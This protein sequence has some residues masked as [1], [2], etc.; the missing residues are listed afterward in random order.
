MNKTNQDIQFV[1]H[2][3]E[4]FED[5]IDILFRELEL[6]TRWQRPSILLAIYSSEYVCTDAKTALKNRLVDML[7]FVQHI[8]VGND[9]N[10]DIPLF[11]SEIA[12]LDKGVFFIEGLRWGGGREGTRAYR[13]LNIGRE[14]FIDQRIRVIF[15]LTE[16]EA[17]D[18]ARY[19]PDF[20]SYRH[21]VV[22]FIDPPSSEQISARALES[23]WQG[24][25][26]YADTLED[27]DAGIA[28]REAMLRDLPEGDE[29]TANRANLLF[30]LGI[31]N[32]RR[33]DF[34][35]AA[36][37]IHITLEIAGKIQDKWFEA[38]CYNAVALVKTALGR[39]DEAVESLKQ[40]S[41]LAPG[42]TFH[43]NNLGNLYCQ[44]DRQEEAMAALEKAIEINPLD[45]VSWNGLGNVYQKLGRCDNAIA[46][47]QKAIEIAPN[48]AYPWIGLGDVFASSER[49]E[50]AVAAYQKA[51]GINQRIIH[52]WISLGNIFEKQRRS[53]DAIR[54]YQKAFEIDPNNAQLWNEQG[55]V[56]LNADAYDEAINAYRKAIE[57]DHGFGWPYSNLALAYSHKGKHTEAIP[58]YQKSIEL[59]SSNRD[60]ASAWNRLGNTYQQLHDYDN[61][62][63]AYQRAVE[64]DPDNATFKKD[65]DEIH[66][67]LGQVDEAWT[68]DKEAASA[69]DQRTVEPG[70]LNPNQALFG[71]DQ[72]IRRNGSGYTDETAVTYKR[73]T[74]INSQNDYGHAILDYQRA[75]ELVVLDPHN[76]SFRNDPNGY[77]RALGYLGEADA[78][79]KGE[80]SA[81]DQSDVA[82][83]PGKSFAWI[84]LGELHYDMRHGA[85][86]IATTKEDVNAADQRAVGLFPDQVPVGNDPDE[87]QDSTDAVEVVVTTD[88]E[89]ASA[90]VIRFTEQSPDTASLQND[91]GDD[92]EDLNQNAEAIATYKK[93]TE[94]NPKNARAWHTLGNL[95]RTSGRY[96]EAAAAFEQAVSLDPDKEVFHYHLGLVH[97]AQKHY[98]D[99]IRAFQKVVELNPGYN[100]AHCTLAGYYRRLGQENEAKKHITIA[101]PT[102]KDETEYNRACFEAICG[103]ADQ[104][105]V[106][107]RDAL[108]KKQTSVD[109]V[110]RDPDFE[111]VHD[112]PRFKALVGTA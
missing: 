108:E 94:I 71:N 65:L 53:Q 27:V 104:A 103:N 77:H 63:A 54:A 1:G 22:E 89:A 64:L 26:E 62:I 86:A 7:Q 52:P 70:K 35:K 85:E 19:A 30:S 73:V 72:G 14:Y 23:S 95:Y 111:F 101:L 47:Y 20:W 41:S 100:L 38:V 107:L 93:V 12:D 112:D 82:L 57:L 78:A 79:D 10:S 87:I 6:A 37:F 46:M 106:L 17:N 40:A 28:L 60:K 76:T 75:V 44:L 81:E 68:T 33:G 18:L 109:W 58:L 80:S 43:W 102:M 48:C 21:R 56:Y 13:A 88:N 25:G 24:I 59:F 8:Q 36:Q 84:D 51:L 55:N 98:S 15:W 105:L 5:R 90:A 32:W 67:D 16:N 42:Q 34:E 50:E 92:H 9:E 61:A 31:L 91:P 11:L 49:I 97:A 74:E 29:S 99:A 2:D 96:R 66:N 45:A 83:D 4:P 110:R 69:V 39:M 3:I